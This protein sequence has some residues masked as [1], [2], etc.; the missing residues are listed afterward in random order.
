[1]EIVAGEQGPALQQLFP[2]KYSFFFNI[3]TVIKSHSL[4]PG[5]SN[6]AILMFSTNERNSGSCSQMTT[7]PNL[8]F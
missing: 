7:S 4:M 2:Y 8:L 1:M 3:Q 6:L 5:A